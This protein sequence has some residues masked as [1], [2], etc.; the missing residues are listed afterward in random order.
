MDQTWNQHNNSDLDKHPENV[1]IVKMKQKWE[2]D[3]EICTSR[4]KTKGRK[5]GENISHIMFPD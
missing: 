4:L 5:E 2:S 3:Q 1:F